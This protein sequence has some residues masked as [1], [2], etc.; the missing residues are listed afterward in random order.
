[1]LSF[2]I[3]FDKQPTAQRSRFHP[4]PVQRRACEPDRFGHSL[5]LS[6]RA[7]INQTIRPC[8]NEVHTAACLTAVHRVFRPNGG[9]DPGVRLSLRIALDGAADRLILLHPWHE[10]ALRGALE[11]SAMLSLS[12]YGQRS[13][14]GSSFARAAC[15]CPGP[16]RMM[17][18]HIT[19]Q[20]RVRGSLN[21]RIYPSKERRVTHG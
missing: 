19:G 4:R 14:V 9:V 8:G 21:R 11:R 3:R 5:R 6:I 18:E 7:Q 16:L 15:S 12:G 10:L 1:M 2:R 13:V 20:Y 17:D